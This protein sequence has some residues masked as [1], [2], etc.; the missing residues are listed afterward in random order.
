MEDPSEMFNMTVYF[1]LLGRCRGPYL[2]TA[3]CKR[4]LQENEDNS[5]STIENND[6]STIENNISSTIEN[7]NIISSIN[8]SSNSD[9]NFLASTPEPEKFP[10]N[11]NLSDFE[12][13]F[14]NETDE[15][16][17]DAVG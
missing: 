3:F 2:D 10:W 4:L 1:P 12:P 16:E 5:N 6:S 15:E 9:F 14:F 8:S 7:N 13:N 11:F 17:T